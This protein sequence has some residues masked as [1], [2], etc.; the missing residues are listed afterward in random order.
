[1]KV[2]LRRQE[3]AVTFVQ[4][5]VPDWKGTTVVTGQTPEYLAGFC[6]V[7]RE[8]GGGVRDWCSIGQG[9]TAALRFQMVRRKSLLQQRKR[10]LRRIGEMEE[11]QVF[12]RDS[13]LFN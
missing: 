12:G 11:V 2:A 6:D 10:L 5:T 8:I 13:S 4:T 7:R 1:M 9:R 3:D